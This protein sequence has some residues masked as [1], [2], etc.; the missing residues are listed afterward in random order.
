MVRIKE[1]KGFELR[2]ECGKK[3]V[4]SKF[5]NGFRCFECGNYYVFQKKTLNQLIESK[6]AKK[7]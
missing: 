6:E 7:K 1:V 3:L 5:E 2:C 4:T